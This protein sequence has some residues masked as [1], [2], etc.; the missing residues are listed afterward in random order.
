MVVGSRVIS[1]GPKQV[2]HQKMG[3]R[4]EDGKMNETKIVEY[5]I[6][7]FLL[8]AQADLH[9]IA[10]ALIKGKKSKLKVQLRDKTHS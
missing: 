6:L 9:Q 4:L 3:G 8:Q 1:I 2:R 10:Y 7:T 5:L